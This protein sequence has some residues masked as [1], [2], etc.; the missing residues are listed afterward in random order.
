LL[1]PPCDT[2]LPSIAITRLKLRLWEAANEEHRG[3]ITLPGSVTPFGN[4]EYE[5]LS[6]NPTRQ[7]IL[8]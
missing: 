6:W 2:P 4:I 5:D 3:F 8:S 1:G 7:M